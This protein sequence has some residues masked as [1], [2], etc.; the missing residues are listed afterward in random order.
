M[1]SPPSP[2]HDGGEIFLGIDA[3]TQSLKVTAITRKRQIIAQ[4]RLRQVHAAVQAWRRRSSRDLTHWISLVRALRCSDAL[5]LPQVSV[6]FDADLPSFGTTN[7]AIRGSYGLAPSARW[8]QGSDTI[9]APSLLFVA[10]LELGL[11]R[12]QATGLPM[13]RVVSISVSGQ[14]HGSVYW[15]TGSEALLRGLSAAGGPL[16]QQ[17]ATAFSIP[18]GP[19]WMDSSTGTE[20]GELEYEIGGPQALADRT[21][22]RAYERFTG[23]QINKI[24]HRFPGAY[25]ETERISLVSSMIPSLLLGAYAPIDASDGAGMNLLNIRWAPFEW[26]ASCLRICAGSAPEGGFGLQERLGPIVDSTAKVGL[27][28]RYF[29]D[30]YGFDARC[31]VVA[32]SGDNPCSLVGLD[33]SRAGEFGVSLGTSDTLFGVVPTASCRPNS[34][35]GHVFPNPTDVVKTRMVML[36]VK[37][38]SLARE[39]V[40]KALNHLAGPKAT[41]AADSWAT[42]NHQIQSTPVGNGG[43][44][45]FAYPENEIVPSTERN[46]YFFFAA[47]SDVPVVTRTE[48]FGTSLTASSSARLGGGS[49]ARGVV[50]SQFMNMR[51]YAGKLGLERARRIVVTGGASVNPNVLQILADVLG[52]DVEG[53]TIIGT[54]NNAH[55]THTASSRPCGRTRRVHSFVSLLVSAALLRGSFR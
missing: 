3:S 11:T 28:H 30:R 35:F 46:G 48:E 36:C 52:C 14:Q 23:N 21:G 49:L 34:E 43:Q 5:F 32:G 42:F 17:L 50:E 16:A 27:V 4:V 18:N 20:C 55:R 31:E 7:G 54:Q 41:S 12:M 29:V 8:P 45:F 24:I 51:L 9:T 13:Q 47:N 53:Q 44:F 15:R 37:N 10:A 6:A 1:S 25:A 40:K 19:I 38:G 26:D 2:G 33:L 39:A 22:S